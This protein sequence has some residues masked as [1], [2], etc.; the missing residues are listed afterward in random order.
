MLNERGA[1]LESTAE[2]D[3]DIAE[4]M[5]KPS[6]PAIRKF[7]FDL[8][9]LVLLREQKSYEPYFA[10]WLE[11]T[12]CLNRTLSDVNLVTTKRKP[13]DVF[14][15]GLNSENRRADKTAIELFLAGARG[16]EASLRRVLAG[17][18]DG[19]GP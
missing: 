13:F 15:E 18:P 10:L 7:H 11:N 12:A 14:A 9:F 6:P 16:C 2:I 8:P 19:G 4:G 17:K 5:S 3:T 1:K